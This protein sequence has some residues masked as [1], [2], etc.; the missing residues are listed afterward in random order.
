MLLPSPRYDAKD[1]AQWTSLERQDALVAATARHQ[2]HVRRSEDWLRGFAA[3]GACYAGVSW[4]KD[5]VV[6]AD[7]VSRVCP[8][9]ALVWVRVEPIFNPDCLLV[10]DAFLET[11]AHAR[12][13]E[14]VVRCRQDA[15]GWHATGTLEAGFSRAEEKYG[16]RHVSG[17]RAAESGTRKRRMT[18][19]GPATANSCAP[20]GWWQAEDVWAYLHARGLPVH[21]AYACSGGLWERDRIRVASIGGKRGQGHGRT[22][23]ERRYYPEVGSR[24]PTPAAAA[25]PAPWTSN[26]TRMT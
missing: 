25:S 17:I 15:R 13:E 16:A 3:E 4:G 12:Y 11:H 18:A 5:S 9:V 14:V 7:M 2:R 23:W 19:H 21:P 22:E 6:L 26:W 1:A 24:D 20:I 10:R 8:Q